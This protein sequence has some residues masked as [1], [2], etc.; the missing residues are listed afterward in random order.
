MMSLDQKGGWPRSGPRLTIPKTEAHN[1][2]EGKRKH[3]LL[4]EPWASWKNIRIATAS[5]A[6]LLLKAYSRYAGLLRGEC[7]V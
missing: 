3:N 2:R 5:A 1:L 7:S 6:F 4:P